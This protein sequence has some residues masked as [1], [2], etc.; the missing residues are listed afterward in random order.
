MSATT[1]GFSLSGVNQIDALL[2]PDQQKWAGTS[3]AGV[4]LTFSFPYSDSPFPYFASGYSAE[5][6][7]QPSGF[8]TAQIAAA[9]DALQAWAN[10]AALTFNR[11][12]EDGSDAVGDIRFAFS[13]LATT[14]YA[15]YPG[16][17]PGAG[18]T[19]WSIDNFKS[20]NFL[21]RTDYAF[22]S[23]LHEIGHTLG[24]KHPG[25][26]GSSLPPFLNDP[27][28]DNRS[29]TVM[30]YS[31]EGAN[32]FYVKYLDANG[33]WASSYIYPSTPTILDIQAI[34]Y[35]YGPNLSY[36]AGDD[37]Y[38]YDPNTPFFKTI[39][40]AGGVDCIDVSNFTT[41]CDIDLTAGQYSSLGFLP[42]T[43]TSAGPPTYDGTDNLGIALNCT[44]ENANGGS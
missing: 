21:S 41:S 20:Y 39:W 26:Y 43:D 37:I 35:L 28:L 9:T 33:R 5:P 44:I 4:T 10:V 36:K 2:S 13:S 22:Q 42:A 24:L 40:D 32:N 11:V 29:K 7:N 30:A 6:S 8:N 16:N 38:E 31:D 34:Q 27:T 14:A 12:V 19:W 15:R 17:Y 18:D 3:N 1:I 23:L 25:N